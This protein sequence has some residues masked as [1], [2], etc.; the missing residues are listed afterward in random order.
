MSAMDMSALPQIEFA[1]LQSAQHMLQS[2]TQ[3]KLREREG[4]R[5]DKKDI[6]LEL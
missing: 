6:H 2:W 1:L 4:T 3:R 5:E